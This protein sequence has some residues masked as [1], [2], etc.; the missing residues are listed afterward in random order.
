MSRYEM[1]VPNGWRRMEQFCEPR[2]GSKA[3]KSQNTSA[4]VHLVNMYGTGMF[5]VNGEDKNGDWFDERLYNY[6]AALKKA[7]EWMEDHD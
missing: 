5:V 7:K 3:Y 2:N 1:D 6:F 4:N